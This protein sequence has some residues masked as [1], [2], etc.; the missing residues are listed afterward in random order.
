MG[1][2]TLDGRA[3]SD[4]ANY[5]D[6][7]IG[8]TASLANSADNTG[9][10]VGD[11]YI[12]IENLRGSN[13][14]DTLIGDGGDN[15]LQGGEGADALDGGSGFDFADYFNAASGVTVDLGNALNN[16][17][18]ATGD[19]F[20]SIEGIRGSAF[21]DTLVGDG[22]DNVLTGVAGDDLLQGNGGSDT[23]DGGTGN[24]TAV[25][26]GNRA[27]YAVTQNLDGSLSIADTRASAADGLDT[28][29]NVELFQFADGTF[30]AGELLNQPPVITSN[31]GGD[32]A[33][34]SMAENSTAVTTVAAT[35]PDPGQALT[36]SFAGGA[37]GGL[38]T[39]DGNTGALAFASA[40]DFEAPADAN[41][42]N[43]YE[44]T[45]QAS[46]GAG[47]IDTQAI[48]VTVA[49]VAGIS[50]PASNASTIT[51]AGEEDVLT[52]LGGVNN[53]QG[54]GGND[55]LSGGGGVDTIDGGAGNDTIDGG[56]GNDALLGGT[57][58]D[59]FSYTFGGGAD[60]VDGGADTD[61]LNII[62]TT[63]NSTLDVVF[64]GT[65]ITNFEGGTVTGVE[66]INA[67]LLDG[68]DALTYAGTTTDIVVNLATS[69]AS[70]FASIAGIENVTG[71]S[72]NDMLTGDALANALSAGAGNDRLVATVNDGNDALT[73]GA[74]I[75]TYD[76]SATTAAATITASSATSAQI[77]TD[78]LATIENII[79]SQGNDTITTAG[80]TNIIDGQ[81]GD[82]TIDG[83]TGN[84]ALLG[85]TGNDTFSYTFGG[86]ADT[87]DGGADT[88][89]L[90]IIGT[91]GNSTL[92]VVF[93]GTSITNFEGGTVTGVEAI[94]ADLLDGTDALTYAGT[95]TDIV[96]NL[97]TSAASGFASI[98]GIE[99]VTGG[100]GNDMLTGDALVNTLNGG[101]GS[102][103]LD[104]GLGN[105]TLV[106]GAGDDT[107]SANN[108]DVLTEAA[109]GGTDSVF[110]ASNTF[111][112]AANLE[113]LTFTGVGDFSG[114][115]NASN[116][117]IT[118]GGGIDTLS[119]AGGSDTLI[120]GQGNDVMNGGSGEDLFMLGEDFGADTII[121][122]DANPTGGQ[123]RLDVSALGIDA[124]NFAAR[125]SIVDLGV[126]TLVTI[127]GFDTITLLG[128]NG[129]GANTI[130]HADFML[131]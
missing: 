15:F 59:T 129:V 105:D 72:G 8:L 4:F 43:I 1:A 101:A 40:P 118:G 70:G 64:D 21:D 42:D 116:N 62:G 41:G 17:G 85:G 128:V 55:V 110:T 95:T 29:F 82:D 45:V 32:S 100:S 20:V 65:S 83:G 49:N 28:V 126:D 127:D 18:E 58:N 73:G 25:F 114:T 106:G 35:D 88:D 22:N 52:G 93:D 3:G 10:A 14:A 60:T 123:D 78:S 71:G 77:G 125:V 96:V 104:G 81:G 74:G 56:T 9:E 91:A 31:G 44:V 98:A 112:L 33:T 51:G 90:N 27:D 102:D 61:T 26:S 30:A 121:G 2:D 50:P 115:G 79:G 86:G 92:D 23:L 13:F 36:F 54:L 57:G 7:S 38:F 76:L 124:D 94:N 109:G 103:T 87:V 97:A 47:G 48:T 24:D 63:G 108:G 107:Y 66:A 46:D 11:V 39:I 37:D 131:L 12:S 119:G 5:A 80:G 117:V 6:S 16:T 68:T 19:T 53:L 89:T 120:G 69:A 111:T 84:D 67:D 122:F 113:N 34:V 75:D 99:N 130:T